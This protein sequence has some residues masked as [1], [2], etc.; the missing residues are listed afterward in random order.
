MLFISFVFFARLSL[1]WG[2][3]EDDKRR[4][5]EF[6]EST[7]GP[8]PRGAVAAD[9]A[10]R[11]RASPATDA[12][13]LSWGELADTAATK[14]KRNT[15]KISIAGGYASPDDIMRLPEHPSDSQLDSALRR[16]GD[17][18]GAFNRQGVLA[19]VHWHDATREKLI[20]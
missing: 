1:L 6:V 18:P 20:H 17:V 5:R 14:N 3:D 13:Q 9:T 4:L 7:E 15:V 10:A 19:L 8:A 2:H 12:R 11:G 16:N